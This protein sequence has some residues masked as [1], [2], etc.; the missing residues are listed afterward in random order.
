MK[1]SALIFGIALAMGFAACDDML[2]NPEPATFPELDLFS[3]SDLTIEQ[4]NG[5]ETVID[6]QPLADAGERLTLAKVTAIQNFPSSFDLVFRFEVSNTPEFTKTTLVETKL[7]GDLITVAPSTLNSAIYDTFTH[8]PGQIQLY[9]RVA[10]YAVQGTSEMRL[11]GADYLYGKYDYKVTPFT[12]AVQ[13]GYDYYLMYRPCGTQQWLTLRLNKVEAAASVYDNGQFAGRVEAP[14]GGIEWTISVGT[15]DGTSTLNPVPA[16]ATNAIDEGTLTAGAAPEATV[17]EATNMTPYLVSIDVLKNTYTVSIAYDC[18]YVP[19]GATS[20]SNFAS[21]LKLFTNDYVNYDGTMRL[22]GTYYFTAQ[23]S[24]DGVVY[25]LAKETPEEGGDPKDTEITTDANG[26]VTAQ[27]QAFASAG[28]GTAFSAT[29]GLYYISVNVG[30][31]KMKVT[32]VNSIQLIG[33]FNDWT[34]ETAPELTS[35]SRFRTWSIKGVELKAGEE[36]KFC[37]DHA[38]A[39]SYG[40]DIN[41][42]VQ[43]G[44]NLTVDEDGTYDITLDFAKQPNTVKITKK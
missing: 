6:L 21:V 36:F 14:A 3:S 42:I 20:S 9:T 26:V 29:N 23:P 24:N 37:V 32:P 16:E 5:G 33:Q 27:I 17:L 43:N 1:K 22:Y 41:N 35:A 15:T 8:D 4:V 44:G 11:G 13:L 7:E 30:S 28:E 40:G 12:P 18:L 10:A 25:L 34:L 38:W 2:P 39:V 19:G 31:L